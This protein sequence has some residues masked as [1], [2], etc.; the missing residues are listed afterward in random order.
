M[1][2]IELIKNRIKISD[3]VG[4]YVSL[5]AKS[6]GE[7]V[8]L[9][10]F[11]GEKT[12]SFTVSEHKGFF[13]CF[14]C[15]EN[16]DI[17]TF[18][19]KIERLEYIDA[20]K[21]LAQSAGVVL[22]QQSK[23]NFDRVKLAQKI[24]QEAQI[25][26]HKAIYSPS[27][28][29]KKTLE[30]MKSRGFTDETIKKYGIGF[31]PNYDSLPKHL[32]NK[33]SEKELLDSKIA[34][35]KKGLYDI[36]AHRVIFPIHDRK[37]AVIA[38]G[39]RILTDAKDQPKYLNSPENP[40]F[41]KGFNLYGLYQAA[42]D[43]IA[44]DTAVIVE[45]YVDV[46]S[47][48]QE[49]IKN[50]VAPLGTSIK[51]EHLQILSKLCKNVTVCLDGDE[52]GNKAMLRTINLIL[53]EATPEFSLKFVSL[54]AGQDPDDFL[55]VHGSRTLLERFKKA[56]SLPDFLF[57]NIK[58]EHNL[59][60]PEGKAAF[61]SALVAEA[62]KV[63]HQ[64][65]RQEYK[66]YFLN[67]FWQMFKKKDA[68]ITSIEP[69]QNVKKLP[70]FEELLALLIA[71]PQLLKRDEISQLLIDVE[72]GDKTVDN[73]RCILLEWGDSEHENLSSSDALMQH[74]KIKSVIL[75]GFAFFID[76]F[77]ES[78]L[79]VDRLAD[80]IVH[81]YQLSVV[82]SEIEVLKKKLKRGSNDEDL[83]RYDSLIG[84]RNQ[85]KSAEV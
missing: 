34:Y 2:D 8:G 81:K 11:H 82:S 74:F 79:E 45:G 55:K 67:K 85:L 9:C 19:M 84:L 35:K 17:F 50:A 36:F 57:D 47:L 52:A 7:Y 41:H 1:S 37:G 75:E 83:R 73:V 12:P 65:L 54:P 46:L 13:H 71:K 20:L 32:L 77:R 70:V 39:G 6:N 38:F 63:K 21:T 43:I 58:K 53:P 78:T 18:L 68:K 14:G 42:A 26:Y 40:I 23:E 29:A 3:L 4:K 61:K 10:P 48:H 22:K 62:S 72:A 24:Y 49:G 16:G 51:L 44:Q 30:Y 5:K 15:G 28:D 66:N 80:K 33:F 59:E 60:L 69:P 64:Y 56:K 25:F 31:A 27:R 76:R